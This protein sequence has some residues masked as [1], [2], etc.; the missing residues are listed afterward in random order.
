MKILFCHTD[1]KISDE[2]QKEKTLKL[3]KSLLNPNMVQIK[4]DNDD[5]KHIS[6]M[7]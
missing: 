5:R 6:M 1:Q 4:S 7:I 3:F 2:T